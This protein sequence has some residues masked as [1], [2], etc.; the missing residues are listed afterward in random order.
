MRPLPRVHAFTDGA[1]VSAADFGIRAA[2]IAAGGPAIALHARDRQGTAA[3]LTA[4]TSRLAAL[5]RP[6]EAA[7]FVNGRPDIAAAAAVQG[8]QLGSGDLAPTDARRVFVRGWIGRS[9]HSIEEAEAA[10]Y[11]GADF[12]IVGSI[13]ETPSHPA[14]PAAGPGLVS[15][16]SRLGVPVIAI[17]GVTPARARELRAAGAYGVA[18]IRS[19]WQAPDPAA[20]TLAMLTPWLEDR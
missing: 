18:A 3:S 17:G 19:L 2:A 4:T 1:I 10:V 7:V 14:Q 6:P 8:V 20:A 15:E 5:A 13:Y 12:L 11:E 9:V 16:V